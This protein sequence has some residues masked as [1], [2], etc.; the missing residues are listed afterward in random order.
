[1]KKIADFCD[2]CS[3]YITKIHNLSGKDLCQICYSKE[4]GILRWEIQKKNLALAS[5]LKGCDSCK[6]TGIIHRSMY[7]VGPGYYD[8]P[9]PTIYCSCKKGM[10]LNPNS[11]LQLL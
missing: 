2:N 5:S 4:R 8:E 10:C 9:D 1:M 11:E 7:T 3:A 6:G